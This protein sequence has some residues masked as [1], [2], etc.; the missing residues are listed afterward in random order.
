MSL[1]RSQNTRSIYNNKFIFTD[2][3]CLFRNLN[4]KTTIYNSIKIIKYNFNKIFQGL[5]AF[6]NKNIVNRN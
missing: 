3:E 6:E 5:Y 1:P 2:S 4:F